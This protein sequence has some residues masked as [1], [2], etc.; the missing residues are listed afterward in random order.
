MSHAESLKIFLL[1]LVFSVAAS[2]QNFS[3]A[4]SKIRNHVESKDYVAAIVELQNLERADKK[5]FTLNN[6]D[7]L[8]ARMAE[9]AGDFATAT[10]NYQSVVERNS[11]LS[12]YALWHLAQ[13]YRSSGNLFLERIYLQKLL[14]L[15]PESLLKDAATTRLTRS[16]FE[17]KD[18]ETAI[19]LL[20][21]PSSV[22]SG[23]LQRTAQDE[24]LTT[25]H[26]QLTL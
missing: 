17:S 7:Y 3:D 15:A 6:Y 11:V 24:R 10:A 16:Y 8:L 9:K 13:I 14:T 21:S 2:A 12:E 5:I 18:Y 25:D 26:E 23:Q 4:H 20:N 19:R 1:L 22:V